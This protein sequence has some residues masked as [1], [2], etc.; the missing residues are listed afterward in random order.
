MVCR[1]DVADFPA[2]TISQNQMVDF[3]GRCFHQIGECA[4]G[5]TVGQHGPM[6]CR[7][8]QGFRGFQGFYGFGGQQFLHGHLQ[9]IAV[10]GLRQ[11]TV[12]R[13][14]PDAMLC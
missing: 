13:V 1:V 5:Q 3:A 14:A 8:F 4:G 11:G 2:G 12:K 7:C 6:R 10:G 9:F